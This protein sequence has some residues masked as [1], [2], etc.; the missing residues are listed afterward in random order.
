MRVRLP[1]LLAVPCIAAGSFAAHSFGAFL[2]VVRAER[3]AE[4][5]HAAAGT[6]PPFAGLLVALALVW[7]CRR[8]LTRQSRR[9]GA[10]VFFLLPPLAWTLQELAERLLAAESVP[11]SG[12]LE[13]SFLLGLLLQL[14]FGLAA[15]LFARLLLVAVRIFRRR[16]LPP[17]VAHAD[18]QCGWRS[19]PARPLKRL[20]TLASGR[21]NRGPPLLAG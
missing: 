18:L 10:G 11:F 8:S 7:L 6:L 16:A 21:S 5:E 9:V 4:H 15:Y 17:A 14:P 3:F 20:G 1:W 2:P 13:P 19:Q 12:A